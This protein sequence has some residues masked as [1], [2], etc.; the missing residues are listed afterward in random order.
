MSLPWLVLLPLSLAGIVGGVLL[1]IDPPDEVQATRAWI[2]QLQ[3]RPASPLPLPAAAGLSGP[4]T[5]EAQP[6]EH[7]DL[8]DPFALR[9]AP[10]ASPHRQTFSHVDAR[11]DEDE[12]QHSGHQAAAGTATPPVP[13]PAP[14]LRLLGTLRRDQQW[15]AIVEL[16]GST[17]QLQTGDELPGSLGRVLAVREEEVDMGREDGARQTMSMASLPTASAPTMAATRLAPTRAPMRSVRRRLIRPG[18]SP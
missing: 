15:I 3:A 6:A 13:T 2:A 18:V 11:D 9:E 17:R 1:T 10:P 12:E 16:Q 7:A 4:A 5:D 14:E 8:P